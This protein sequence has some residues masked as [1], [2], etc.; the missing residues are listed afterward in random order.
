VTLQLIW[1]DLDKGPLNRLLLLSILGTC[2]YC[3]QWTA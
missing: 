1:V 2:V 3:S